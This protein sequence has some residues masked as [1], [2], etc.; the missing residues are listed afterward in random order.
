MGEDVVVRVRIADKTRYDEIIDEVVQ[1]LE[2]ITI[3]DADEVDV[4][5]TTEDGYKVFVRRYILEDPDDD[6]AHKIEIITF[7]DGRFVSRIKYTLPPEMWRIIDELLTE[8]YKEVRRRAVERARKLR[9]K[10]IEDN[11]G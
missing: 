6:P 3:V 10:I 1:T 5:G 4:C 7:K 8:I 2:E 11:R 9:V